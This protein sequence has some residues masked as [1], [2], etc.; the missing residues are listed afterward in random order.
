MLDVLGESA[1]VSSVFSSLVITKLSKVSLPLE[2]PKSSGIPKPSEMLRPRRFTEPND[3]L[4][5]R[6]CSCWTP[7]SGFEITEVKRYKSSK[8]DTLAR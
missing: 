8:F 3:K 7:V 6:H 1:H 4:V 2:L 5:M